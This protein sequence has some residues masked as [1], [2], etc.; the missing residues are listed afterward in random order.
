MPVQEV[1]CPL[2]NKVE[3]GGK[4]LEVGV[5]GCVDADYLLVL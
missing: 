2:C 4:G 5:D 1:V 3:R